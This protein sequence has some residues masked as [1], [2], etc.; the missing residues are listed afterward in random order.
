VKG[1]YL[2]KLANHHLNYTVGEFLNLPQFLGA[3]Y[4]TYAACPTDKLSC[5]R[6][7]A[8]LADAGV[9]DLLVN[10]AKDNLRAGLTP[11]L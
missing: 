1:S 2:F 7:D 9:S 3:C 6:V 11:S 10:M 5:A 4:K 8:W